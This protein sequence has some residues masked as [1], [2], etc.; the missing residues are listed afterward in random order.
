VSI[1][2]SHVFTQ[3]SNENQ[4]CTQISNESQIS[5]QMAIFSHIEHISHK[6]TMKV[7]FSHKWPYIYT[8]S[9]FYTIIWLLSIAVLVFLKILDFFMVVVVQ[10][11]SFIGRWYSWLDHRGDTRRN[12]IKLI[13][14]FLID[15]ILDSD[16]SVFSRYNHV[17][18]FVCCVWNIEH[19]SNVFC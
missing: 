4:I 19:L 2:N 1:R 10:V 11:R 8:L 7:K 12:L 17:K 13:K 3:I 14:L 18:S 6:Y 9:I 5:T 15:D 16:D